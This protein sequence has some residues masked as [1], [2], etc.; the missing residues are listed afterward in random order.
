MENKDAEYWVNKGKEFY[1]AKNYKKAAQCYDKAVQ[2][3]PNNAS[4][5]Y[6]WGTAISDLAKIQQNEDLFKNAFEKYE[7]ATCINLNYASAFYNW[8]IAL[9]DLAE[10]KQDEDLLRSACEK[11]E[12]A[13]QL[14]PNDASAFN[15]WG[16]AISDLAKI[17][18]NEDLFK[19]AF[20]KY[21][22]ATHLEPN[23][24]SAFNNWG[25]AISDLAKI[26]Q[27]EDLF[28]NAF[29]KYEQATCINPNYASAFY[30]WGIA[31]YDLAEIKQDEDLLK[32]A[33]E[34]YSK[35][36]QSDPDRVFAFYN[37]GIALYDL[38]EIKQDEN[39]Y[40]E[41][42]EYFKKSKQDILNILVVLY[43]NDKKQTFRTE[44]FYPLLDSS[45]TN[46]Y[47]TDVIFFNKITESIKKDEL[48][49]YKDIYIRSI[50]IISKLY[51]KNENEKLVAHYSKKEVSKK[52]L[53]NDNSKFR[54]NAINTFNDPS[55]GKI[56]LNFLYGKKKSPTNEVLNTEYEVF[57]GCF[58]FDYDNLNQFRLYGKK[59]KEEGTGLSLVFRDSFFSEEVKMAFESPKISSD[60]IKHEAISK[61]KSEKKSTLFRCIYI[62]PQTRRVITVGQKEEYRFYREKNPNFKEY[63]TS[64]NF[65]TESIKNEMNKLKKQ[66]KNLNP[67]I[68]GQLLINLRYLTKHISFK[69]EQ[70][71][72]IVRIHKHDSRIDDS[73]RIYIEYSPK[74]SRHIKEIY[75]G[76]KAATA[77]KLFKNELE[78]K[79]LGIISCKISKNPLA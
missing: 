9:Y 60:K 62:D 70:E 16:T 48:D 29:E 55:E 4:A 54:L 76:P 33:C 3:D 41:S 32:D 34:K 74:V 58:T 10:I 56:L 22:Q 11:Y 75:F 57:A 65:I 47:T 15:N 23:Y 24:A 1:N 45:D 66:A 17:Q 6:N 42:I 8:G 12:Q 38:A 73:K 77:L 27:N 71:C 30:N 7:Q 67:V 40:R 79:K 21:K 39:L 13:A 64:I 37:W 68:V 63:N 43:E 59:R 72:R 44:Y 25:I 18:Q 2:L 69:E 53:F 50:Y 46:S 35:A 36:T 51:V 14:D 61:K 26:Q 49:E 19:N 78:D 5:F 28:K 31:L 52:L 20:E